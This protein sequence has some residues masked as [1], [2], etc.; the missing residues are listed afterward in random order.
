MPGM[1]SLPVMAGLVLVL[2]SPTSVDAVASGPSLGASASAVCGRP[3]AISHRGLGVGAPE[4][5]LPGFGGAARLGVDALEADVRFSRDQVPVIMHDATV[6]RT[7][8]GDGRVTDLTYRQIAR[9]DAGDGTRV[10]RLEGLVA[11]ASRRNVDLLAELKPQDTT[12]Q[13]VRTVI[14]IV[15]AGGMGPRTTIH[16]RYRANLRRVNQIAPRIRTMLVLDRHSGFRL[17]PRA[18]DTVGVNH[19][20]VTSSR[21]RRWH[22]AG[23][24]VSAWT[25]NRRTRWRTLA[26]D[27]VDGIV[28][29]RPG[30]YLRWARSCR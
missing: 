11:L 6:D 8:D 23:V 4:S 2:M 3:A 16:S 25:V 1:R 22:R 19:R 26:R 7:T 18:V 17:P 21:V 12:V 30:A 14:R 20:L 9:L 15:R 13:Q 24:R 29:D 5:T 27:D 10:P 28:T